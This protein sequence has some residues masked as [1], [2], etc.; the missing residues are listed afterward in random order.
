MKVV[1]RASA[2][3]NRHGNRYSKSTSTAGEAITP[4]E[5]ERTARSAA[6]GMNR[7][8]TNVSISM[9]FSLHDEPMYAT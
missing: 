6:W 2:R 3:A 1:E 7:R 4:F 5:L 9:G 8:G